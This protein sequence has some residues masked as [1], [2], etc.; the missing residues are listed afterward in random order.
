[1]LIH[2]VRRDYGARVANL[3]AQRL[4]IPPHREGGQAQFLPRPLPHDERNRLSKLLDWART[5]LAIHHTLDSLAR[6][7]SMSPRT[8]QRQFRDTVGCSP[9]E[10]LV[11]ERVAHAKDLLQVSKHSLPLVAEAVG[12]NSQETFR[13]HFRRIAGINPVSYRRQFQ[14]HA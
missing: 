7:A 13:R 10:W 3:V 6:R 8:L 5:H 11:R 9:Y 12:F 14:D 2:L 4:V 1:M